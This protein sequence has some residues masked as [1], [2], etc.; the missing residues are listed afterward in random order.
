LQ[1]LPRIEKTIRWEYFNLDA[2]LLETAE[3]KAD[4][5]PV[6]VPAGGEVKE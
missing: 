3:I 6:E 1:Q 2:E 4:T 5:E